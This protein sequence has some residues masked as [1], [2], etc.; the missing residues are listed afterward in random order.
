MCTIWS[1]IC[2]SR[3]NRTLYN[4]CKDVSYLPT[5]SHH[6]LCTPHC[7]AVHIPRSNPVFCVLLYIIGLTSSE[8]HYVTVKNHVWELHKA[9]LRTLSKRPSNC[10]LVILIN[11]TKLSIF[12]FNYY[13]QS[14]NYYCTPLLIIQVAHFYFMF[15]L[16]LKQTAQLLFSVE[17]CNELK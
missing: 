3:G 13:S 7:A 11:S 1:D 4:C 12:V 2:L 6:H 16:V 15:V 14:F 10:A 17:Y 8:P 5:W 9:I